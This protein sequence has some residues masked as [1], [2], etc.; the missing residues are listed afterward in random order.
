MNPMLGTPELQAF[1]DAIAKRLGLRF[2]ESRLTFLAEVLERRLDARRLAPAAYLSALRSDAEASDELSALA[3]ELTVGE[4]YFFRQRDHFDAFRETVLPERLSARAA[5]RVLRFLSAG[6]ASGEEVYSLAIV[7]QEQ[8]VE[9]AYQ[10]SL[11]GL[12]LNPD[13]L[14]RARA[15]L[16]SSW[17]LRETPP[18]ACER[19]FTREGRDYRLARVLRDSVRFA[20]HNLTLDSAQLLAPGSLDAVF[21][22][23][24]LMYF[25]PEHAAAIVERLAR[26]L[27]P[28]GF[29]FLGHA[30]T[31][32]GL[33]HSF[34]LKHSHNAFYYQRRDE[35]GQ[36]EAPARAEAPVRSADSS[37]VDTWLDTVARSS[38]R[39]HQLTAS[40]QLGS[41]AQ[42]EGQERRSPVTE[43]APA[44]ATARQPQDLS[45]P[46]ELLRHERYTEA[47]AALHSGPEELDAAALLLRAALL[48]HQGD[49]PAAERVCHELLRLDDLNAGAHYLLALCSERRG[50]LESAVEHDLTAVYLDGGF[51][52]P[53]LHLG[54]MARRRRDGDTARHQLAEAL[55]LLEREDASRLLLFGG[56]FSRGALLALCRSEL[57][58][59]RGGAS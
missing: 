58:N 13:A 8:A 54:L 14:S 31:L 19:W 34:H 36:A 23:N 6:C 26:A 25:T 46:L 28:G 57:S 24:V 43:D 16:Y 18:E 1:Q 51:A 30:E 38:H 9:P 20:Q 2:D 56:G 32:R 11:T 45:G 3:R 7:L 42:S 47:L 5:S 17:S 12:D 21:C 33:S 41:S 15:G 37:W 59:L 29:L 39:I 35:L 22:R 55:I 50:Q 48:T 27:A 40:H 10:V 49:L 4:T 53:H 44:A 52:M